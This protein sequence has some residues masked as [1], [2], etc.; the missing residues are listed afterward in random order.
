MDFDEIYDFDSVPDSESVCVA[1]SV[2][3][4]LRLKL[5]DVLEEVKEVENEEVDV[6]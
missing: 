5:M 1:D 3:E 4:R 6:T 2:F